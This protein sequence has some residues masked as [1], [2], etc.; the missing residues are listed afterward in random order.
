MDL[1]LQRMHYLPLP[2]RPT[3]HSPLCRERKFSVREVNAMTT[4]STL[5]MPEGTGGM[6]D[7]TFSLGTHRGQRKLLLVIAQNGKNIFSP[8]HY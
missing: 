1:P 2:A 6:G 8:D 5:T 4:P 3:F 7:P